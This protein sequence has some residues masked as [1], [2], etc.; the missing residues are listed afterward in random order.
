MS[1]RGKGRAGGALARA[2]RPSSSG[3]EGREAGPG[4]DPP[5]R[6]PRPLRAPPARVPGAGGSGAGR[7]A[8][9]GGGAGG[10]V[11]RSPPALGTLGQRPKRAVSSRLAWVPTFLAPGICTLKHLFNI[12][13]AAC[14]A[15]IVRPERVA[16]SSRAVNESS[17]AD[18]APMIHAGYTRAR[19]RRVP[20]TQGRPP[21]CS[22]DAWRG[23]GVF[24]QKSGALFFSP[25]HNF[26]ELWGV[27]HPRFPEACFQ[28]LEG[29]QDSTWLH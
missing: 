7:E 3:G 5:V 16:V 6:P 1:R 29:L 10:R 24:M 19:T 17:P 4:G 20:L 21:F 23:G 15:V 12:K 8:R 27:R 14:A 26:G 13:E 9:G 18:R 28:F 25:L 2:R 11:R 22:D